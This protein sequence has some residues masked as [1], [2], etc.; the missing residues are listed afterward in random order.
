MI[1]AKL[2]VNDDGTISVHFTSHIPGRHRLAVQLEGN[3]LR[4]SPQTLEIKG[5]PDYSADTSL[6]KKIPTNKLEGSVNL[7]SLCVRSDRFGKVYI[8][9]AGVIRV[10]DADFNQL[11]AIDLF[12]VMKKPWG[13]TINSEGR[14]IVSDTASSKLFVFNSDGTLLHEIGNEGKDR[15]ELKTP[16][17]VTVDWYDNIAVCDSGNGRI[18]LFNP[19]TSFKRSFGGETD[20]EM[21]YP[22]A[23]QFNSQGHLIVSESS[24]WFSNYR[25]L[26]APTGSFDEANA[27]ECLKI[28]SRDGQLLQKFGEPG[29]GKGQ[30]WA[31]ISVAVDHWDHIWVADFTYGCVQVFDEKGNVKEVF[32]AEK[33]QGAGCLSSMTTTSNGAVLY[34]SSPL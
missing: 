13:F 33:D 10:F 31:P 16:L 32:P 2:Q 22:V 17:G 15:G 20:G 28:F 19:D 26:P 5:D 25:P 18:Q 11:Y 1:Q 6:L 34:L 4:G 14:I 30:F 9:D 24:L 3:S 23:I 8:L 21:M 29:E 27:V 7:K 12:A